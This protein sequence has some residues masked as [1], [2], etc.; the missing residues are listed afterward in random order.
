[1]EY[2]KG[3]WKAEKIIRDWLIEADRRIVA[4]IN[5][6][7]S[8]ETESDAN[9]RLIAA[10]VNACASVNPDNPMAVAESVKDM[11]EA[12]KRLVREQQP[13]AYQ[14]QLDEAN[15]ALS[16]AEGR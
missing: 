5:G 1:M 16:K 7:P 14:G 13:Y 9:A 12:L 15:K 4:T 10:A 2:T 8:K 3:E 6:F 11:Y